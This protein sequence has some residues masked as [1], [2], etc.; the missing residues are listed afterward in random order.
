LGGEICHAF[1]I[2]DFFWKIH[3]FHGKPEFKFRAKI[4]Q[5]LFLGLKDE[6]ASSSNNF[7]IPAVFAD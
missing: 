7:E 2:K 1:S 6:T 3:L 5:K 4:F